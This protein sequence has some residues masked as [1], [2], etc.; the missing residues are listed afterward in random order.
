MPTAMRVLGLLFVLLGQ[1]MVWSG[2]IPMDGI[3]GTVSVGSLQAMVMTAISIIPG[4][5]LF[6]GAD[7]IHEWQQERNRKYIQKMNEERRKART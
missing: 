2:Y 6:W 1:I 5:L 7:K 4:A 3:R